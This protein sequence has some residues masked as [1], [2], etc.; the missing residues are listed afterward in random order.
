M[1]KRGFVRGA[2]KPA[3]L[4]PPVRVAVAPPLAPT[5]TRAAQHPADDRAARVAGR[6]HRHVGGD[7]HLRSPLAAVRLLPDDGPGRASAR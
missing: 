5:G 7:V 1:S 2:R 6:H 3:P 4:V